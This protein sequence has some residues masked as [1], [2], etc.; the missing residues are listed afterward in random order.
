MAMDSRTVQDALVLLLIAA[1]VISCAVWALERDTNLPY[2]GLVIVTIVLLKCRPRP[3]AG[4]KA[5]KARAA[6]R[7]MAAPE[8]TVMRDGEQRRLPTRELVPGDLLII[9]EG[10]T[11]SSRR[12]PHRGS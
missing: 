2:E 6:L 3:R 5:E 4:G 7:A 9:S 12:A 11:L 8:A 1:A 10:D